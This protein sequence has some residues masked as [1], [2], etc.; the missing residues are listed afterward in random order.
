MTVSE[1][2]Q[3]VLTQLERAYERHS[4]AEQ[5]TR[6]TDPELASDYHDFAVRVLRARMAEEEDKKPSELPI[7]CLN[8]AAAYAA[9]GS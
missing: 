1:A 4:V 7:H 8:C 9:G 2:K 6:P 5:V 3:A